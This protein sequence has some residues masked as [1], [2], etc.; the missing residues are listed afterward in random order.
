M[1][2]DNG[3]VKITFDPKFN[4]FELRGAANTSMCL[5]GAPGLEV[6]GRRSPQAM[7]QT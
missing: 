3:L 7:L 4:Q 2:L 1:R 6:D 5:T